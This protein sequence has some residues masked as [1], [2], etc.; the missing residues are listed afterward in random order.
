MSE[1]ETEVETTVETPDPVLLPAD[2]DFDLG[3]IPDDD[4]PDSTAE[5]AVDDLTEDELRARLA[6]A[7][8]RADYER[9]QRVTA[10]KKTWAQ[11]AAERFPYSQPDKIT[12]ESHR[13]FL[14]QAK[15]QDQAFRA[16]AAPLLEK[17][18]ADRE[19]IR[20]E[21]RAAARAEVSTAWGSPT[22]GTVAGPIDEGQMEKRLERSRQKRD[23][24]GSVKALM[25][26]RGI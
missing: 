24:V 12:A 8:K 20:E 26:G 6:K 1:V 9:T 25:D 11:E 2:E 19:A 3:E 23:L 7:E 16:Q 10:S 14:E 18:E 21:E 22:T 13:S 15:A 5:F 17:L 4:E